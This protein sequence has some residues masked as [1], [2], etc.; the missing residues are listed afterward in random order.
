MAE[1]AANRVAELMDRAGGVMKAAAAM[2]IRLGTAYEYRNEGHVRLLGPALALIEAA[3]V[4]ESK[5]L[6]TL[7]A[8]QPKT[9]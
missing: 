6:A 2:G 1:K 7:R 8:I 3:G 4:P 5:Q 9:K